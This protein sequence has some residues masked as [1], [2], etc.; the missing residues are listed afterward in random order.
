MKKKL[1]FILVIILIIITFYNYYY[2]N[3]TVKVQD[4]MIFKDYKDNIV[5]TYPDKNIYPDLFVKDKGKYVNMIGTVHGMS[6][7][8]MSKPKDGPKGSNGDR[9]AKG[10]RG[11]EGP[12]G[13]HGRELKK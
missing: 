13:K 9:G 1:F 8:K 4:A 2:E 12:R 6:E 11:E 10:K 7:I 3:F 5:G